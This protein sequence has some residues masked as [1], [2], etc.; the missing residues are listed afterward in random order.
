MK[1][2]AS[3]L[4]ADDKRVA[5]VIAI[6]PKFAPLI[7]SRAQ[8]EQPLFATAAHALRRFAG[9]F[10][11]CWLTLLYMHRLNYSRRLAWIK[12]KTD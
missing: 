1:M 5:V 6:R 10:V 7:V 8:I 2:R 3:P 4:A 9:F 11:R 12:A